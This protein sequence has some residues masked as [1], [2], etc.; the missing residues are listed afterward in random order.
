M[1]SAETQKQQAIDVHSTQADEFAASYEK[2][3]DPYRECFTY[4]RKRL[5]ERAFLER[6]VAIQARLK[7]QFAPPAAGD[8]EA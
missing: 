1:K 2:S 6:H 8:V 3:V 7:E 5:D 4:S